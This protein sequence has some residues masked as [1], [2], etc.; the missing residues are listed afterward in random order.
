[1]DD[2]VRDDDDGAALLRV[3]GRRGQVGEREREDYRI[4]HARI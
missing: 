3:P 1:M 2:R 4:R